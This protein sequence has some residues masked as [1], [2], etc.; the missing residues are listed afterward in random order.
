MTFR[1]RG[2]VNQTRRLRGGAPVQSLIDEV[3]HRGTQCTNSSLAYRQARGESR[4]S[5]HQ[6]IAEAIL[7]QTIQAKIAPG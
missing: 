3:V 7:N 6:G 4:A 2:G 1:L 5:P